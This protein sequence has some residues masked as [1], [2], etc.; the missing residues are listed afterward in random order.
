M[1][2]G[3][4]CTYPVVGHWKYIGVGWGGG[5]VKWNFLWSEGWGAGI[6]C[7]RPSVSGAVRRAAGKQGKNEEGLGK[8]DSFPDHPRSRSLVFIR[9]LFF[10]RSVFVR[11]HQLRAWNRLGLAQSTVMILYFSKV[12]N[13]VVVLV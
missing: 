9:L 10:T 13:V 8:E 11:Y 3:N 4:I 1:V 7:S 2:P 6:A 5:G 12:S